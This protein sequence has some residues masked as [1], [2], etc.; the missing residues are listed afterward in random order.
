MNQLAEIRLWGH[1]VGAL[2]YQQKTGFSTFE[3]SPE[4][5]QLGA[6]IAPITM[7]LAATKYSF[8]SLNYETFHGLPGIFADALPDD[9]GNAVINA[10]L[11]RQGRDTKSFSPVERLL[12]TGTRGMGALEFLPM[13]DRGY[14][15]GEVLDMTSL[16]GM[17]QHILDQ[18]A[19]LNKHFD[20][21]QQ[22]NS[23]S[24]NEPNNS[25][26]HAILQVGTSAGG[27]R[28]K[29]VIAINQERS[30]IRSG[31]VPA[32]AGFEHYLLKFDGVEE[33]KTNSETFGDPQGYGRMEYAYYLMA[34]DA[35]ISMAPS[36][37]L[38]EGRRAHFMTKRFDRIGNHKCHYQSLCGMAHADFKQPGAFS[39]EELLSVARQLRLPRTDAIELYRRMVF[40]VVARNHDDHCKNFGFVKNDLTDSWR[41]SPAFDVAYSYKPGSPWV[42]SHQLSLNGKRD[43]FKRSDLLEVAK[44]IANFRT[45]DELIDEVLSVVAKWPEYAEKAGVDERFAA[46]IFSHL[47]LTI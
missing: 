40:N 9:F 37:L 26:M 39:Y 4:W 11:S 45:A 41:L 16:I 20:G 21:N 12:Y 28:A 47:R 44:A 29:A 3:Y 33:H 7:P 14:Q 5:R 25:A 18:R 6:E 34:L 31:Q 23:Q 38:L 13:L 27:A 24:N 17:A 22:N 46:D 32:P 15:A 10:W 19:G 2:A 8:P 36:E 35:G 30:E 1:L 42:S 43:H